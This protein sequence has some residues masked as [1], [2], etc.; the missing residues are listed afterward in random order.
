MGL[1]AGHHRAEEVEGGFG[2]D[3]VEG[4]PGGFEVAEGIAF[5]AV[6]GGGFNLKG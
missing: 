2:G 6:G 1:D 5:G 4:G 3:G